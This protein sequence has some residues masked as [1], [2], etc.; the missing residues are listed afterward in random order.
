MK[1]HHFFEERTLE[2]L[3]GEHFF[4]ESEETGLFIDF[5]GGDLEE[6][7]NDEFFDLQ[8]KLLFDFH[9]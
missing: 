2:G 6:V 5:L 8:G 1:F 9:K 4:D 7:F 3:L